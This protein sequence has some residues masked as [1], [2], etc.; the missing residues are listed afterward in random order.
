MEVKIDV[1][2]ASL[3]KTKTVIKNG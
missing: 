3:E 2:I 1:R